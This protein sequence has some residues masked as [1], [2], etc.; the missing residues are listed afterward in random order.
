MSHNMVTLDGETYSCT[1]CDT[2][3]G[4]EPCVPLLGSK[5]DRG[6]PG[7]DWPDPPDNPIDERSTP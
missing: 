4:T 7:L 2:K 5:Q 6:E 1:W 3:T